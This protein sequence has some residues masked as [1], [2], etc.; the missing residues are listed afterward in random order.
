[1]IELS[2]LKNVTSLKK[3]SKRV[4]R[5]TGS[6]KGKTCCRGHKGDKS[7]SGYKKRLGKEGGQLPLYQ[8]VPIRGFN[9]ERFRHHL[10]AI[11]LNRI[12]ALFEDG[13]VVNYE[14]M[15]ERKIV[16]RKSKIPGGIKIL[17][18]GE[19]NKKVIIEANAFSKTAIKKLEDRKIEFKII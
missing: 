12:E 14:T 7:R 4:G 19:L 18:N 8:K 1:M 3:S 6:K 9:S 11:S 2:Q 10:F 13:E 17:G 5:G 16:P 15:R